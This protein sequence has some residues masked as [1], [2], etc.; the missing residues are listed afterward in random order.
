MMPR[1]CRGLV[2]AAALAVLAA[3]HAAVAPVDKPS[4]RVTVLEAHPVTT[5]HGRALAVRAR[6]ENTGAVP[7]TFGR[8]ISLYFLDPRL[9]WQNVTLEACDAAGCPA[10]LPLAPGQTYEES[11][12]FLGQ[13]IYPYVWPVGGL[14]GTYR[15]AF[16]YMVGNEEYRSTAFS[17][18]FVVV[19]TAGR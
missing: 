9:G 17:D 2:P 13:G 1:R 10:F 19:D 3:C 12:E 4:M 14:S 16:Y 5:V 8:G 18:P 15:V 11:R 6:L 7:F